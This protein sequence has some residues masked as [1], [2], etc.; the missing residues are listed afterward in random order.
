MKRKVLCLLSAFTAV[1]SVYADGDQ[2]SLTSSP[3]PI[4]STKPFEVTIQTSDFG[5]EVYCYTWAIAGSEEY[6]ASDWA[7][8]INAKFKMTGSGGTYTIKVSD[9]MSFYG[10]TEAQL[11]TV[12]KLGFIARTSSGRQT[13]DCIA[14]VV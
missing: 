14:E 5:G 2:A 12:T 4:V 11:E 9:L 1:L 3:S 7:G 13:A 8:A 6:P 10:L